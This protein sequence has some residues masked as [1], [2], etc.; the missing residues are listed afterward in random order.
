VVVVRQQ[1]AVR[2][3]AEI[4]AEIDRARERGGVVRLGFG[5]CFSSSRRARARIRT[6]QTYCTV[7]GI[8]VVL[9]TSAPPLAALSKAD[10]I[11]T[12]AT[13]YRYYVGSLVCNDNCK[14]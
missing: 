13:W 3:S 14:L 5:F 7:P 11:Q 12:G 4:I 6:V 8:L 1:H 9:R 2:R 10:D